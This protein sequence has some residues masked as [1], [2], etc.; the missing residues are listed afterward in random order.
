MPPQPL[1]DLEVEWQ[2][3]DVI[4]AAPERIRNVQPRLCRKF[5]AP[6]AN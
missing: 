5:R 1:S 2:R 3:T 6:A 4:W